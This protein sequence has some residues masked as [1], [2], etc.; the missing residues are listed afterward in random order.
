VWLERRYGAQIEW[1]PF[2]LHPE[3]PPEGIAADEL[4]RRYGFDINSQHTQ[5]FGEAGLQFTPHERI[6]N[7]RAALNAAELARERGVHDRLH[8]R[9]MTA[10]WGEDRDISDPLVL[11]EEGA[12]VGLE[13]D[14]VVDAAT[15]HPYQDRIQGSTAAVF[16]MGGGGV[17]AFAIDDKV[18]I[19]GAQPHSLFEKVMQKLSYESASP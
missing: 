15:T 13:R 12:N 4:S 14:E 5:L 11:A 9:L 1:L 7:S 10:Y 2:D 6:P 19:P 16:E 8:A 18:L 17:P 3:Y